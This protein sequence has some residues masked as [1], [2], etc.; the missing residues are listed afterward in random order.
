MSN[1]D[2]RALK[3]VGYELFILLLSVL[4]VINAFVAV[5]AT[6]RTP[7]LGPAGE[8]VI[9]MDVALTPI[10]LFDFVYRLMTARSRRRYLFRQLGWLDLLAIVPLLRLLRVVAI[11]RT[12]HALRG[13]GRE[14][15][16]E[17]LAD[18]RANATFLGTIFLVFVVVEVAGATIFIAES[19]DAAS[20]IKTA[21]D[22]IWWGLVTITTVG[23]GD[24]YPVTSGGR[25]V[26]VLLLFAGIGLFSVLTGFI[27]NVFLA[28]RRRHWLSPRPNDPRTSLLHLKDMLVEQEERSA[29]MRREIEE[30]ERMLDRGPEPSA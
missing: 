22:A 5:I 12:I 8:V 11:G 23:Y 27:A 14:R 6:A 7:A 10:F 19:K 28:P 15:I 13:V 2:D 18:H 29:Q 25:F 24:Y 4:S 20:N 30:L 16:A 3:S 17:E 21:G 9:V 26:G 1:G